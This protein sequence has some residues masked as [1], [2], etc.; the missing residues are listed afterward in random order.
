VGRGLDGGEEAVRLE[1]RRP[2]PIRDEMGASKAMRPWP[3]GL[4]RRWQKLETK[5]N[6]L[7]K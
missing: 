7:Q 2:W 6:F 3:I 5:D 4:K 1:E